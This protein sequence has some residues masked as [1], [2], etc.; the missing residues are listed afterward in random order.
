MYKIFTFYL[1]FQI[2]AYVKS[3]F[4]P[5]SGGFSPAPRHDPH[6]LYTLSA[7][8]IAATFDAM[9]I[10]DVEKITKY[11]QGLQ[12]EDGSFHG[13]KWGEVDNRFSFCA[14]AC[15]NLMGKLEAID[16]AKAVEFVCSCRNFD[17]GFGSK[18][19]SESHAGLIY[20]C[21]GFLSI[22]GHLHEV[23]GDLLGW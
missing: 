10:L 3:C 11:I 6:I 21:V 17:G 19:G 5:D 15:L 1:Q 7:V 12:Q 4:D 20:C 18:P 14:V 23:D 13:D 22:T 2:L 8:Q 9:D 16:V